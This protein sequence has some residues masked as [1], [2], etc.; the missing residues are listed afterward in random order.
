MRSSLCIVCMFVYLMLK[1]AIQYKN[2]QVEGHKTWFDMMHI[3]PVNRME[4]HTGFGLNG[5]SCS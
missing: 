4:D 5:S 1:P 2:S 3:W